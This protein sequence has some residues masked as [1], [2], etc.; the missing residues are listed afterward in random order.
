MRRLLS[1]ILALVMTVGAT[2][3]TLPSYAAAGFSDVENG[4]WSAASIRY[5][6]NK[7]YMKG[8][9]GGLF[10][11]EGPLTRAMVA[12]VLWRRENSPAPT[13]PSGFD[14]VSDGEWYT[15]AVAWA[16]E[17]GV[18]KGLSETTFGPEKYITREQLAT[19]LFRFSSGAPVSVPER[20][21]L[22][23]FA[24]DEKISEWATEP[25]EWAVESNLIKSTDG[26]RLAPDGFATRE[27]FAAIIERYDGTFKLV[28]REPV[29]RSHYT[30]KP[31][32]L[33]EDADIYV[34]TNGDDSAA[35]TKDAPI[36]TFARAVELA[37]DLKA[38]KETSVVAAFFAG[39]YGDPAVTMT[40]DDSGKEGAPVVYCA[41]GDGE[42]VFS[43]GDVVSADGFSDITAE[44]RAAMNF[45]DRAASKIKKADLSGAIADYDAGSD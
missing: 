34:S 29:L 17:T 15:D 3:A 1:V 32:P 21:D 35:G 19:M 26:N 11:P 20:A 13:A 39:D 9:G 31:Y 7:G 44:D 2:V 36:R 30:E 8:V 40:A 33:V 16:K 37:R 23:P 38:T 24:D 28:F 12:T 4:R 10:D 18:V 5:A 41:Y 27:Q 14:D 43:G 22:D 25:L 45:P 42:V 6:V